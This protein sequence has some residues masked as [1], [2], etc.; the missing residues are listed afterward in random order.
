V[1]QARG[2]SRRARTPEANAAE[3]AGKAVEPSRSVISA[4]GATAPLGEAERL[5][6]VTD[7]LAVRVVKETLDPQRATSASFPWRD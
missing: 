7:K 3:P 6:F 5:V 2:R 1:L 4:R